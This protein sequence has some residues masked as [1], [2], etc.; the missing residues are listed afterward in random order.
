MAVEEVKI[1]KRNTHYRE[2]MHKHV[3][4]M[5][6]M[7]EDG[8]E[9]AAFA[10]VGF[11]YRGHYSTGWRIADDAFFGITMFPS[12]MTEALRKRITQNDIESALG[13]SLRD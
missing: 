6:D 11:D 5:C 9:L 10:V 13:G 12:L 1:Q 2:I 4:E 7:L 3:D 8:G